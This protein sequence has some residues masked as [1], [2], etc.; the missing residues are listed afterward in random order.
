MIFNTKYLRGAVKIRITGTIPERF[1]NL[2]ITEQILLWGIT[3]IDEDLIA[4]IGLDDFFKI[5]PLVLRSATRVQVLSH[6]GLPFVIKRAKRR[7]MMIAGAV[8][9]IVL[10]NIMSSYVWFVD[11]TGVKSM[12]E[13]EIR[14]VAI[15]NGL[16]P[17]AVIGG[18]NTKLIE[19]EILLNVPEVAWVGIN[20]TGT[21]AV[22]EVVEKTMPKQ[23]TKA[24]AHIV[25]MK[26]GVIT[27]IIAL[28]GQPAV[29]KGDTVKKGDLLVKGFMIEPTPAAAE[30]Q[31]LIIDVP[32]ELIRAKGIIKAWVWYESY[33]EAE[34]KKTTVTRTGNRQAEVT[35]KIGS[36]E[37]TFNATPN[38]PFQEFESEIIHKQLPLW[39][40]SEFT[41]ESTIKLY[42]EI[43]SDVT[44]K[45]FSE[46]RDEAHAKAIQ[47]VQN[48]IPESAQILS[49]NYEVL[50]TP[51][52]N[53]VR[54]KVN[55]ETIE[56]IGQTI[57]ISQ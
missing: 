29:K 41:V 30:G 36:S 55:V 15:S 4:W 20:F 3:K 13:N 17:G 24:P 40:N 54:V 28:A 51:E 35:L 48:I 34:L 43:N 50:K 33:A 21:R 46:A 1:I 22:I 53:I 39:R 11:I 8:L 57:N 5:R 18:L 26:D 9:F 44:V 52:E 23:E 49:R 14:N 32:R 47:V 27:E 7:K 6:R 37:L 19:R 10:L 16:K 12:S 42:Y 2:C 38:R 45:S 31:P 25:A 56:D